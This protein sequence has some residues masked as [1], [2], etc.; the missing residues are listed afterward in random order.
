VRRAFLWAAMFAAAG[1][2]PP[3][4]RAEE[5]KAA[6]SKS[7]TDSISSSLQKGWNK[8]GETINP[9][10]ARSSRIVPPP[11]DD[12]ISL[13]TQA[14]PTIDLYLSFARSYEQTGNLADAEQQYAMAL[15]MQPDHVQA[16]TGYAQLKNRLG[17]PEEALELYR[18][19][20]REHPKL[21]PVHNN[22]GLFLASRGRLDEAA[23]AMSRAVQLDP[24][25]R[26]YRN[27]LAAVLLDMGRN[28]EAFIHLQE[29]HGE[30]AAHY[31]L[32]FLLNKKK[33]TQEAR[34]E[35]ALALKADPSMQ[36]ARQ[37]LDFLGPAPAESAAASATPPAL[38]TPTASSATPAT[39]AP[40]A[41]GPKPAETVRAETPTPPAELSVRLPEVTMPR[42]LPA[43]ESHAL[44]IDASAEPPIRF[45]ENPSAQTAPMPPLLNSSLRPLPPV[46]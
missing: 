30:A 31:N 46:R 19:A 45:P 24:K 32:G 41:L 11:E 20:A 44:P 38:M 2:F 22:L 8:L 21:A 42:R 7:W 15:K 35:F 34:Q 28:S 4:L 39:A 33:K 23:A 9:A 17:K 25:N 12:S 1:M 36:A 27:N 5:E 6:E 29:A 14:K 18:R 26:L 13:K 43:I 37:W 3:V 10:K 16:L 40:S